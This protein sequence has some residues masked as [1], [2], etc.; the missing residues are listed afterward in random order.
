MAFGSAASANCRISS[1]LLTRHNRTFASMPPEARR[2]SSGENATQQTASPWA[3]DFHS[4]LPVATS[5]TRTVLSRLAEASN[6][7]SDD[8]AIAKTASSCPFKHFN[9]F[10]DLASQM[11][12]VLSWLPDASQAPSCDQASDETGP[13]WRRCVEP[14]RSRAPLGKGSS[15]LSIAGEL[16][17]AAGG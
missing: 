6:L 3:A 8:N 1:P 12:T 15:S 5:Q 2:V 11:Q 14:K 13:A 10:P 9:R 7:L 4:S 16:W 17:L